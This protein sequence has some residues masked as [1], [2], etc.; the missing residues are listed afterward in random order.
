MRRCFPNLGPWHMHIGPADAKVPSSNL[1]VVDRGADIGFASQFPHE[2]E[3]L[4]APLTGIE[5]ASTDIDGNV[6]IVRAKLTVNMTSPTLDQVRA[7]A[8][9]VHPLLVLMLPPHPCRRSSPSGKKS[10]ST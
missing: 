9:R 3:I 5:V 7:D 1:A 2:E 6:L 4:F 10:W 8:L